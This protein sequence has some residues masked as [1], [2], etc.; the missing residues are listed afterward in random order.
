VTEISLN[1][2]IEAFAIEGFLSLLLSQSKMSDIYSNSGI[3][4]RDQ[5]YAL[6]EYR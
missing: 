3:L 5:I 1:Q 6:G 2:I 4:E